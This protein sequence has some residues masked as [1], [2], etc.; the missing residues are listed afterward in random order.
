M[1]I[2]DG[3]LI[4]NNT[5]VHQNDLTSNTKKLFHPK[6]RKIGKR[7]KSEINR[8]LPKVADMS[9]YRPDNVLLISGGRPYKAKKSI[10]MLKPTELDPP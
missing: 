6:V 2:Y 10:E 5:H 4:A 9:L 3:I 1:I 7:K 8:Y